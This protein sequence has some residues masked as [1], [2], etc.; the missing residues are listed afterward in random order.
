MRLELSLEQER[1]R[2]ENIELDLMVANRELRDFKHN[3]FEVI[4]EKYESALDEAKIANT[5]FE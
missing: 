5:K 2:Y 1:E 3:Q 4:K